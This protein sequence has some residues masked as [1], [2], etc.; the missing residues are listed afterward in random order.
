MNEM[1]EILFMHF[2]ETAPTGELAAA[3]RQ[4]SVIIDQQIAAGA[5]DSDTIA[6]YELSALR[7]GFSAGYAAAMQQCNV[8][9]AA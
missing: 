1:L 4:I 5:V 6:N 2:L 7:Y 3:M 9:R 8:Q